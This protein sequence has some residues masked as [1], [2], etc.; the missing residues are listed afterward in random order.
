MDGYV[1]VYVPLVNVYVPLVN[2]YVNEI[3]MIEMLCKCL[4]ALRRQVTPSYGQAP[5]P[6]LACRCRA[7]RHL[8]Y[9]PF[10]HSPTLAATHSSIHSIIH[11]HTILAWRLEEHD[12]IDCRESFRS[13]QHPNIIQLYGLRSTIISI[14]RKLC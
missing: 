1:N 7:A 5:H 12:Y 11:N 6:M 4:A 3:Y 13:L 2:V 9:H 14:V 10:H 8:A